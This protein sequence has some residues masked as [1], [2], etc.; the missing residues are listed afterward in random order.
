MLASLA[1]LLVPW[2]Q[3][4]LTQPMTQRWSSASLPMLVASLGRVVQE[5]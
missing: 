3:S 1:M 2:L 4:K 5:S